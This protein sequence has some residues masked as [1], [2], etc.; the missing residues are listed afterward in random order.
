MASKKRKQQKKAQM[1][2]LNNGKLMQKCLLF[3][4]Q[5]LLS[6][7]FQDLLNV[8]QKGQILKRHTHSSQT[9]SWLKNMDRS[10]VV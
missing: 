2:E 3:Q 10:T 8:V 5:P 7:I 1:P 6:E 9:L 4:Q